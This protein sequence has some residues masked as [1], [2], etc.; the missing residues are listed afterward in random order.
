MNEVLDLLRT[1]KI[2][3]LHHPKHHP[4]QD[5]EAG[6]GDFAAHK[7]P[8]VWGFAFEATELPGDGNGMPGSSGLKTTRWLNL[9]T[10]EI[11]GNLGC[12]MLL[13]SEASRESSRIYS[14]FNR[15]TAWESLL[16]N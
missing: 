2:Q 11:M 9:R 4:L 14:S 6:A 10:G 5:S 13:T 12:E 7:L 16:P 8:E 15:S 3:Y 1:P